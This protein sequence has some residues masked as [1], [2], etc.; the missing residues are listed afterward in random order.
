M[1]PGPCKLCLMPARVR[2]IGSGAA[3]S[4]GTPPPSPPRGTD[5]LALTPP[6]QDLVVTC[7]HLVET[8]QIYSRADDLRTTCTA[9]LSP[10]CIAI[11]AT[12]VIP[13]APAPRGAWCLLSVSV[14][15][16]SQKQSS[17]APQN[18]RLRQLDA[19][20]LP[21]HCLY[22]QQRR[23]AECIFSSLQFSIPHTAKLLR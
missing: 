17:D 19:A 2:W 9:L 8:G 10:F 13:P 14:S 6:W 23:H 1:G 3:A 15:C 16:W 18:C 5:R 7:W 21:I 12:R 20:L 11:H 4:G 22:N